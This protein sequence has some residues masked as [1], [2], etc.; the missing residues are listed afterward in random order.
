M[1]WVKPVSAGVTQ[2]LVSRST[3]PGF[4]GGDDV[5]HGYALRVGPRG[6][7]SWEVDDPSSMVPEWLTVPVTELFDGGWHHVAAAWS[8]GS[9]AVF[10]DGVE[11][12]RQ[13]S[14]SGSIN[15]ATSTA[16]MIGGEQGTPFGY[17][18][19][20]DEVMV[21]N[22]A[23]AAAEIAGCVPP[24]LSGTI[25]TVA[26]G[27]VGDGGPASNANLSFP[28]GVAVDAAGNLYIADTDNHRVREVSTLG[29]ITTVAGT[30]TPGFSGDGGPATSAGLYSPQGVAV[31]AAGNLYIAEH[32]NYRVRK[33]STSG[34]ITTVA[35]NGSYGF[36]GD[37]G[38]ATSAALANP[39]GLAVDAVGNLYIADT[40]NARV[41]K[42][43]TLGTI[44]TVAG[45]GTPGFSGDGGAATD[46]QLDG[47]SG[48][49]FDAA[50]NLYVADKYNHR[51]R[52]VSVSGV[53]TTVA[54]SGDVGFLAG[55]FSGDGGA[56]TDAQLDGPSGVAF[57]AAGNL[58]VADR[59]NNSVRKVSVSG[60]I[61]TVAGTDDGFSGDG[62]PATNAQLTSPSG[63]AVDAAGN[64]YIADDGNDRVR[65]VSVSGTITTLAGGSVQDG[66]PAVSAN[67]DSPFGVAVDAA[68]NL[69]IA[70]TSNNRVRRVSVSGVI[71]TVAGTGSPGF[72]GDG[73]PATNAQL[74]SPSG[75]AVDAAGNLYIADN[76][77]SRVRRVSVSGVIT[78]VAGT[79]M[80]GFSGDGG[81]AT[82]AQ[83]KSPFGVAVDSVG[84]LYIADPYNHRVRKVS[85]SGVITTVAGTGP[86]GFWGDGEA[87][88]DAQLSFP[89]GVA[90]DGAGNLYIADTGNSRVRVVSLG[91]ISTKAGT[92]VEGFSGDGGPAVDAQLFQPLGVA[93]DA[94]GNLYV[95]D[96][97]ANRVRKVSVSGVITTV[98]GSGSTGIVGGFSGD[99][100][101]ADNARLGNP[102][103]LAVDTAG[104][105]YIADSANNRVRKVAA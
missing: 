74:A 24:Q 89:S 66:G 81:P 105:L 94:A 49:A 79:G 73:G 96:L 75:V 9:M 43:S 3:G 35:G 23:I 15:P 68:G 47:P 53:I 54:G 7:V 63:V 21:F 27:G 90:V 28:Y 91:T 46:A 78:T 103:G 8:P 69:Y 10:I 58:Y 84:N 50:G 101:P 14:R 76:G 45:N 72:S 25:A 82:N 93:V 92:G 2:T 32:Y 34:T 86:S 29:T 4:R 12:A 26:G 44:T 99:G 97:L 71:T 64:L 59:N 62:G 39:H 11:V 13:V 98:A 18:G 70:D 80:Y 41:R 48:V 5:S 56:A 22:R 83:L 57:D 6:D 42:V 37:G 61:S 30:G 65:R 104:N 87:A 52:R 20:I 16:F 77:N 55:G 19:S 33:V 102:G 95:V 51:V 38:P 60:V 31:D 100:G 67:L 17:R 85:V 40:G 36:S 1:A 88:T